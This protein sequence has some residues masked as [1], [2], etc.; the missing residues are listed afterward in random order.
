VVITLGRK[1][2]RAATGKVLREAA[3]WQRLP[4]LWPVVDSLW[5]AVY[6]SVWVFYLAAKRRNQ[7]GTEQL[8]LYLLFSEVGACGCPVLSQSRKVCVPTACIHF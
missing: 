8:R 6:F 7:L 2:G 1:E 4:G 3:G 5:K